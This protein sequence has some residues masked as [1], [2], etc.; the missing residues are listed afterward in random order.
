[1]LCDS[2]IMMSFYSVFISSSILI[3]SKINFQVT[4][5]F[6]GICSSKWEEPNGARGVTF[7]LS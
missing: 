6:D 1:M 2:R 7:F 5:A 4:S 3:V